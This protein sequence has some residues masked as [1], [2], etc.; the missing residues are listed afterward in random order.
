[1]PTLLFTRGCGVQFPNFW[2]KEKINRTETDL[3]RARSMRPGGPP[4]NGSSSVSWT[5]RSRLGQGAQEAREP[6]LEE[7]TPGYPRAWCGCTNGQ[8]LRSVQPNLRNR[9]QA[10]ICREHLASRC[11]GWVRVKL[12]ASTLTEGLAI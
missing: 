1:M 2:F 4:R 8:L 3:G 7:V 9:D 5:I 10:G 12:T 6:G 11:C